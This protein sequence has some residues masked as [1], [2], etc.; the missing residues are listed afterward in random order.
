MNIG[1]I[2]LGK[3]GT[4][5]ASNLVQS[6]FNV[7]VHNRTSQK[8]SALKELG[9]SVAATPED[10]AKDTDLLIT[11]LSDD[12][13]VREVAEKAIPAMNPGSIHVSMSTI[14]PATVILLQTLHDQNH[15]HYIASPV[16]GRPPAAAA[17]SLYILLSGKKEAKQKAEPVLKILSQRIFDFGESSVTGHS[18][19]LIMN[20]MIFTV[21]E[22]LSEVL[23]FAEKQHIDKDMMI[24]TLNN[25]MF[26]SPVIKTY[27]SLLLQEKDIPDGFILRLANK[28]LRLLQE[29]AA[30]ANIQLPLADLIR[31]H[32]EDAMKNGNGEKDISSMIGYLRNTIAK[33]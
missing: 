24:E 27:G 32:F 14:S 7:K 8:A 10:A 29:T 15:V 12:Q 31:S 13:A 2:G 19:K 3:M 26:A 30:A 21:L 4:P 5:I 6:G 25:T 18:V 16:M 9:A 11:M 22:M 28:D 33:Q 20:M 23:L 17:R 1:F